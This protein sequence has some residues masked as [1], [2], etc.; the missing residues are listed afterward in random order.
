MSE[1]F[2]PK[3]LSLEIIVLK[4]IFFEQAFN[5]SEKKLILL[6]YFNLYFFKPLFK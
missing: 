5:L 2:M 1:N 4:T 3:G 6:P